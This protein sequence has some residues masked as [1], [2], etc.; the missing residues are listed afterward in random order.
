MQKTSR[1]PKKLASSK[2]NGCRSASNINNNSRL[3]S[4]KNNDNS[5]IDQ[6]G[7]SNYIIEHGKKPGR[8]KDL[9]L[10]KF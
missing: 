6:F 9:K 10:S 1:S 2:N 5:E 4:R 8:S 7:I 3:A